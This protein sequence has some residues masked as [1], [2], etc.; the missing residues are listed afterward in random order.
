[1]EWRWGRLCAADVPLS[2]RR[3]SGVVKWGRGGVDYVWKP[4]TGGRR[5]IGIRIMD[6]YHPGVN[7]PHVISGIP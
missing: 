7:T 6:T 1:M 4:G 3:R 2:G 5:E